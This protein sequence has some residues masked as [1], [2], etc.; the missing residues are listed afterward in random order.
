[1]CIKLPQY[2]IFIQY[3]IVYMCFVYHYRYRFLRAQDRSIN[4]Q[5]YP[6]LNFPEIYLLDGGYKAF[7]YSQHTT[8]EMCQPMS[9]MP[10]IHE[11]H[12]AD[13]RHFRKKSKSWT[14]GE[15]QK[16]HSRFSRRKSLD[17]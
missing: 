16:P 13:L 9:Y 6:K 7:Y 14:A 5:H 1:M 10:M 11:D 12:G 15:G 2:F 4:K 17:F 3:F 8:S